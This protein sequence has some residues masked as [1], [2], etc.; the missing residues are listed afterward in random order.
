MPLQ[1]LNH[2]QDHRNEVGDIQRQRRKRRD[3]IERR[4]R[5]DVDQP[6]QR[7][8][9][10]HEHNGPNRDVV[11]GTDVRE[12]LREG[13]AVVAREGPRQP[14]RRR[15]HGEDGADDDDDDAGHH[16]RCGGGG[17]DG[18]VEDLDDG[19]ARGGADGVVDVADAVEHGDDPAE[20]E[21]AVDE[22]GQDH[23]AG[24]GGRWVLDFFAHVH[25]TIEAFVRLVGLHST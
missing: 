17:F 3:G 22:D 1:L 5:G 2:Q 18:L 23:G 6:Q 9:H 12:E 7:D 21:D 10:G 15:E 20:A 13:Q 8:H 11:P 25:D 19:I 14:G 4:R 24:D 16:G